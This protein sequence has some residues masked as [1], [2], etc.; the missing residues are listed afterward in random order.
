MILAEE[1][2]QHILEAI[3]QQGR[4]VA[5][6]LAQRFATSEDTIRRDLRDLDRAGKLRRVHGGAVRPSAL[7]SDFRERVAADVPRKQALAA[8]AVGLIQPDDI[9]LIDAGSTNLALAHLLEDGAAMAV[10]TNCPAI[11]VALGHFIRTEVIML[12]GTVAGGTGSVRGARTLKALADIRA[13]LCFIGA[14]G[15]DPA[16]GLAAWEGEDAALKQ[17]MIYASRRV[18]SAIVT[19]KLAR[20]APFK[21]ADLASLDQIIVEADAPG[22]LLARLRAA[23]D[24]PEILIAGQEPR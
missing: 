18:V 16:Y 3:T 19:E 14:C 11:A 12:G 1:R 7:T 10:V 9:V 24:A 6:D 4:V 13:D 20:P 15:L 8:V 23:P 17:A 5:A 21:V 2:R 22:D